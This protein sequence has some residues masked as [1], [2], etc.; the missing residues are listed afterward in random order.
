MNDKLKHLFV[1]ELYSLWILIDSSLALIFKFNIIVIE[2]DFLGQCFVSSYAWVADF[3]R[4]KTCDILVM[5]VRSTIEQRW[6]DGGHD[7]GEV[8]FNLEC[9][10]RW[11]KV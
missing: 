10:L 3:R 9:C 2:I 11:L 1:T 8:L 6:M 4:F 7:H 5:H